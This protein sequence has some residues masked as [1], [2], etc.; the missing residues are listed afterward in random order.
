MDVDDASSSTTDDESV[1]G[2]DNCIDEGKDNLLL[3]M[4]TSD[5]RLEAGLEKT[6]VTS[7]KELISTST[8]GGLLVAP[9]N[10][11]ELLV[12]DWANFMSHN[13][14]IS[15]GIT[16]RADF[17]TVTDLGPS[18]KDGTQLARCASAVYEL[19]CPDNTVAGNRTQPYKHTLIHRSMMAKLPEPN[20]F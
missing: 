3:Q 4:P 15:S 14:P 9:S 2:D 7:A 10:L 16:A 12:I 18:F 13:L 11:A 5:N 19:I 1:E 6:P 8:V 17:K 20:C